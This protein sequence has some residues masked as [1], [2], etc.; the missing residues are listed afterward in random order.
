MWFG[1]WDFTFYQWLEEMDYYSQDA[2]L[3]RL[4]FKREWLFSIIPLLM[5]IFMLAYSWYLATRKNSDDD[6]EMHELWRVFQRKMQKK[7]IKLSLYSVGT[8]E[9]LIKNYN[10]PDVK[11]VWDE[12]INGSFKGQNIAVKELKRKMGR[13]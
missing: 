7:G 12:L 5:V 2:L 11:A 4:N 3:S 10:N 8:S 9:E 1:Q 13:L 6:S